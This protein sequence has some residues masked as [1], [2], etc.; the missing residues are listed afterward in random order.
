[1]TLGSSSQATIILQDSGN[2]IKRHDDRQGSRRDMRI[3]NLE[4]GGLKDHK[5]GTT[6]QISQP[7]K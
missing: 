4:E 7:R 5:E 3:N 2:G 6:L 1:M